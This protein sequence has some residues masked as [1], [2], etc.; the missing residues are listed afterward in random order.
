MNEIP[1]IRLRRQVAGTGIVALVGA[2][3]T[4]KCVGL[5][6]DMDALPIVEATGLPYASTKCGWMHACGHDGHSAIL[7]GSMKVLASMNERLSGPVKALFQ[8]AEEG[9]GGALR[10]INEGALAN[11]EVEA[12]FGLHGWPELEIGAIGTRSGA[13]FAST[14]SFDLV[15]RGNGGH[16]AFPHRTRDPVAAAGQILTAL[17]SL[18]SRCANPIESVVVSIT[19]IHGGDAYNVIPDAVTMRGTLRCFDQTL[20]KQFQENILDRVNGIAKAMGVE[21]TLTWLPGGYPSLFCDPDTVG[22]FKKAAQA[23]SQSACCVEM[24][25]TMGGED[26]AYYAQK[27]PSCFWLLGVRRKDASEWPFLHSSQYDFNDEAIRMGMCLHCAAVL[28]FQNP[29]LLS[30]NANTAS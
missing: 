23:F 11:P 17:H 25:P 26:F 1:G 18:V 16:A 7:A 28:C 6:A 9:G 19:S 22:F 21:S 2:E 5:R 15:V 13:F 4:G 14:D 29:E 8:P 30:L 24:P 12:M 20:R 27:V 10:M 3:K